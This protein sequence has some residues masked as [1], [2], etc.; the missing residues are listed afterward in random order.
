MSQPERPFVSIQNI[1]DQQ[2]TPIV[3]AAA[4]QVAASRGL[5]REHQVASVEESALKLGRD[6]NLKELD[7]LH[8]QASPS[9][10]TT[11]DFFEEK[12]RLQAEAQILSESAYA[13]NERAFRAAQ[14]LKANDQEAAAHVNE[15]LP[16]YIEAATRMA[17]ADLQSRIGQKAITFTRSE[18]IAG[19]DTVSL[20]N[21]ATNN[22]DIA[23]LRDKAGQINQ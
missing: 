21:P 6:A 11:R 22:E 7:D 10:K 2:G 17:D 19:Y 16:E 14:K 9:E 12:D 23:H 20:V 15:N 3:E 8:A 4:A 18:G 1:T 5:T 13:A